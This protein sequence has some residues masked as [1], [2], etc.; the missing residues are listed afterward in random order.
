MA[1]T[2]VGVVDSIKMTVLSLAPSISITLIVAGAVVY[3]LAHT[4]PAENRG[5]WQTLA[6]GM[7]IGGIIIAAIWGAADLIVST[8]S[9]LLK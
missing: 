2:I 5:R 4:Q 7:V 8:S 1:P 9:T 6:M 3:G